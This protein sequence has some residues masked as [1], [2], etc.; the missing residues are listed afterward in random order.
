MMAIVII[1]I[2]M[3]LLLTIIQGQEQI[4]Q[5]IIVSRHCDRVPISNIKIPMDPIDWKDQLGLSKGQLT[6]LGI[7]QV[8]IFASFCAFTRK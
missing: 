5:V 6:G 1:A 3:T 2:L 7:S 8:C 4:E